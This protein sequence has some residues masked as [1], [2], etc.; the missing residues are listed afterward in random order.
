M[1]EINRHYFKHLAELRKYHLQTIYKLYPKET[2]NS[3][4]LELKL[5]EEVTE[6]IDADGEA[7]YLEAIDLLF[8]SF[9]ILEYYKLKFKTDC[10]KNEWQLYH[11]VEQVHYLI[12]HGYT[13]T[14]HFSYMVSKLI[15][16]L[17]YYFE[18]KDKNL[19]EY[20]YKKLVILN[21]RINPERR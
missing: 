15:L 7:K 11:Y 6:F 5:K 20:G 17:L 9:S 14:N 2:W 18:E 13:T 21:N 4:M 19:F 10:L 16:N 12:R 1:A 8:V 3:T